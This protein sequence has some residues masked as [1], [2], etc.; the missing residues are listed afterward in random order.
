MAK[1]EAGLFI[2]YCAK[3]FLDGTQLLGPW[4]ELAY[5]RICDMIYTTNDRLPDDDRMLAWATKTGRRWPAV[6]KALTTG[7]RPK[8]QVVDGRITNARCQS[9]LGTAARKIA[10]KG[11]AGEASAATGKSL[12]NLKQNRTDV[13]GTVREEDRTDD[14]TYPFNHITIEDS[15]DPDGSTGAVAPPTA[16]AHDPI[17]AIYDRGVAMLGEHRRA[18]LGKLV[19]QYGDVTVLDAITETERSGPVE[20]AS[21][22]I[23]CLAR[24]GPASNG[25]A[26]RGS[27]AANLF[28]GGYRAAEAIIARHQGNLGDDR[29]ADEPLLDRGRPGSDAAGATR[30]L[31]R[32]PH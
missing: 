22:L 26:H 14:R 20:P 3:D 9:A 11:G 13:R 16:P 31:A 25:A 7:E 10:Q 29:Q 6:K 18:L 8:L 5:R 19:K 24:A 17:K 30:R 21:F 12:K 32:R 28:E 23:G 1:G 2:E 15:V 27:P 4:E